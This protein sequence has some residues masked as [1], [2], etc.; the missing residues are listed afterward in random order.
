MVSS[1]ASIPA[2]AALSVRSSYGSTYTKVAF[3]KLYDRKT[4]ITAADLLND[5]VMPFFDS[6]P[7]SSTS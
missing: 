3:A 1:R 4:S 2:I 7:A 5:R 6:Q